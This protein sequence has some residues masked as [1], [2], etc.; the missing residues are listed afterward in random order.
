MAK[1][2]PGAV[3]SEIRGKIA[4]TV[5]TKN[6]SGN[7]IRNR[8]TPINPR[9]TKQVLRRQI[10]SA[11]SAAW[12]GLTQAQRDAWNAS[13][14]NFPQQ[15]SLG[16][17]VFLTG[18]QLYVR[19]NAN[20]VLIGASQITSPP[21]PISFA[22]LALGV[23]T[24]ASGVLTIPFTPT[25]VAAGF[26]LIVRATVAASPGKQFAPQSAFRFL[27]KLAAAAASPGVLTTQY[28]AV[29]GSAPAA[30]LKLFVSAQLIGIAS[31]LVG[32]EVRVAIITT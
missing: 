18:S 16:Q 1:F 29:F 10:L 5:F 12:R 6:A 30:G 32:Q 9:S 26:N 2:T 20:L 13:A 24:M 22:T 25:P 4:A 21:A 15:D 14:A 31:G 19:L 28:A 17:T 27:D 7:S 23:A 11:L 8:A 3:I